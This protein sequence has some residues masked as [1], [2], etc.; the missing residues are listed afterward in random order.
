[1]SGNVA[2]KIV[3]DGLVLY[4]DAANTKSFVVGTTNWND[5]S[6]NRFNGTLNSGATFSSSNGGCIVFDGVDDSVSVTSLSNTNFPQE[7]GTISIWYN[8]KSDNG[9]INNDS[10]GIFD[11]YDTLRNHFFIR[12]N[13]D[14]NFVIQISLQSTLLL[15]SYIY[16]T[17]QNISVDQFHN[18]VIT[19]V[20]GSSSSVKVYIDG[21]LVSSGVMSDSSWRPNGQLVGFGTMQGKGSIIKIY[22]KPLISSEVLQNYNA[23]KSRFGLS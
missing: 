23:L 22:N 12:N 17:N 2:P 4:L 9:V 13:S 19:Y 14:V 16:S 21:I 5:L 3:R 20:C 1:M 8:I 7:Q 10:K 11:N 6:G 15:S 18:I